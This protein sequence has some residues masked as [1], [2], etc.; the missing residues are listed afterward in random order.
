LDEVSTIFTQEYLLQKQQQL[1]EKEQQMKQQQHAAEISEGVPV[2]AA[3]D[4]ADDAKSE[5]DNIAS[6]GSSS[7]TAAT[8]P[9]FGSTLS[10]SSPDTEKKE[11][12][13]K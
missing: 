12:T 7:G 5:S 3:A 13:E 1:L 6:T 8:I 4:E 11:D 2:S 10:S 9:S